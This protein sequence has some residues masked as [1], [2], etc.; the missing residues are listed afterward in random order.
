MTGHDLGAALL[1]ALD[2]KTIAQL[3][4]R[5]RPHLHDNHNHPILLTPAQAAERL[6]LHPKTVVRMAR[7]GRLP[8][9]KIGTGWRFHPNQLDITPTTRSGGVAATC[10]ISRRRR[11]DEEPASVRAIRGDGPRQ[12]RSVA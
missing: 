9:T 8:A 6:A 5:L 4:E 7:D 12:E 10:S 11:V 3:A 1:A 2:E